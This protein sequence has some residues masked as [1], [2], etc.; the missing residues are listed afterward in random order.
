MK[1]MMTV[2]RAPGDRTEVEVRWRVSWWRWKPLCFVSIELLIMDIGNNVENDSALDSW[3]AVSSCQCF[4]MKRYSIPRALLHTVA[5]Y[6]RS[7]HSHTSAGTC[8]VGKVLFPLALLSIALTLR[9]TSLWIACRV[10]NSF[11]LFNFFLSSFSF[12][13]YKIW[14]DRHTSRPESG[15]SPS[16]LANNRTHTSL[17]LGVR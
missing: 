10:I 6:S 3:P 8:L 11:L 16:P 13:P 2:D 15:A 5:T 1:T 14:S 7:Q 12:S 9:A 4:N 17:D